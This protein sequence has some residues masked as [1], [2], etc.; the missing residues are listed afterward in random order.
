M[1]LSLEAKYSL[2]GPTMYCCLRHRAA[3]MN[4][5]FGQNFNILIILT[6]LKQTKDKEPQRTGRPASRRPAGRLRQHNDSY[7]HTVSKIVTQGTTERQIHWLYYS[8]GQRIFFTKSATC[9]LA[10]CLPLIITVIRIGFRDPLINPQLPVSVPIHKSNYFASPL[11][12][13]IIN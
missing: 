9:Y 4:T 13:R 11:F 8:G 3:Y 7:R 2:S 1:R 12:Y 10:N 6:K 5:V